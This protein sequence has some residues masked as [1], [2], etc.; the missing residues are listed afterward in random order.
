MSGAATI[1]RPTLGPAADEPVPLVAGRS[2]AGCTLCCKLLRIP[3]LQKPQGKW[4]THCEPRRGCTAYETR[5]QSCREFFCGYLTSQSLSD[6]WAPTRSRI[7]LMGVEGGI[8]AVVDRDRPD[9]WKAAPYYEQIKTWARQGMGEGWFVI[10]RIDR[11]TI[12]VLPDRE[13]DLGD[14]EQGEG[15]EVGWHPTATGMAYDARKIAKP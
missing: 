1:V 7:V 12:A 2:C 13:V 15:I 11:K 5:P 10:V 14:M 8:A 6:A 4:C 3:E 9:A